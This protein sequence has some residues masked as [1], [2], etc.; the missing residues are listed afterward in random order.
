MQTWTGKMMEEEI[1]IYLV[2]VVVV[3]T[4]LPPAVN[5]RANAAAVSGSVMPDS[6]TALRAAANDAMTGGV[7]VCQ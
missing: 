1:L 4:L 3:V 6:L 5:P 7:C 2:V